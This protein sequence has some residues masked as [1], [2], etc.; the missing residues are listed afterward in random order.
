[1]RATAASAS[2]CCK[3]P[4]FTCRSKFDR[5]VFTAVSTRLSSTSTSITSRPLCAKTCAMPLPI[6][7]PPMTATLSIRMCHPIH[8]SQPPVTPPFEHERGADDERD[9]AGESTLRSECAAG[10]PDRSGDA[11][12]VKRRV[13]QLEPAHRE[14]D[15]ARHRPVPSQMNRGSEP[16]ASSNQHG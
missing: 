11:G 12:L 4:F 13:E 1:M 15:Q 6:V 3:V 8:P 9:G 10:K 5:I 16:Q 2:S 14:V 7:P